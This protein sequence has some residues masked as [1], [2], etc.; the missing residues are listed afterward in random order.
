MEIS[1]EKSVAN[2]KHLLSICNDGKEGYRTA[3]DNA[4]SA[5]L[6]GIFTT[7][8]IQRAEFEMQLKTCIQQCNADPDNE[9][10]GPIGVLHRTWMD[11]KAALSS[12]DNKAILEA[13]ITGEKAAVEA[14][15]NALED[16]DL[17]PEVRQILVSQRDGI[18]DCLRNIQTLEIQY[19][20]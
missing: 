10:G 20:A 7:Y 9:S 1:N 2:L 3:S 6:K 19:T 12:N 8:S 16:N 18:N 5:E 14:Y 17:S 11:I 13:C 4:D 15:D